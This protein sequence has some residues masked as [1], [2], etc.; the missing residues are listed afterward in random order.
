[1]HDLRRMARVNAPS[2]ANSRPFPRTLRTMIPAGTLAG[3]RASKGRFVGP[4]DRL[5]KPMQRKLALIDGDNGY[6]VAPGDE[7]TLAEKLAVLLSDDAL[8]DAMGERGHRV[9]KDHF[10]AD[11]NA[12]FLWAR[13]QQAASLTQIEHVRNRRDHCA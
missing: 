8:C 6:L 11:A 13:I 4:G 2:E 1:M 3:P 9:V 12:D 10:S 7:N 5:A